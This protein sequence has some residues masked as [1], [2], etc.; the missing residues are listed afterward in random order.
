MRSDRDLFARIESSENFKAGDLSSQISCF[1]TDSGL[2]SYQFMLEPLR[3]N[4]RGTLLDLC[5]GSGPLSEAVTRALGDEW[6]IILLDASSRELDEAR[7]RPQLK[8]VSILNGLAQNIPLSNG[9]CS[10]V[11]SHLA[12]MLL[13][14]LTPALEEIGRVLQPSG[15]FICNLLDDFI[16]PFE[17]EVAS[18]FSGYEG[19][20]SGFKGWGEPAASSASSFVSLVMR[21]ISCSVV[22]ESPYVISCTTLPSDLWELL[23][24]FFQ[25]QYLLDSQR[26]LELK[27]SFNRIA[28]SYAGDSRIIRFNIPLRR[29]VFQTHGPQG[30]A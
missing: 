27:E 7:K 4:T 9:E 1:L 26:R 10:V 30:L 6:N 18:L 16:A 22:D 17:R 13:N 12:M 2:S 23:T 28:N 11:I 3:K 8:R 5:G 15:L 20:V 21:E 25:I 24:P 29:L 19:A 14:P